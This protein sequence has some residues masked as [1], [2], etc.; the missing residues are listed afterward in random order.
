[1][2]NY[3][4]YSD[5]LV[6]KAS[7]KPVMTREIIDEAPDNWLSFYP[8][9]SFVAILRGL[10]EKFT[11]GDRSIWITGTYGS[12][13]SYAALVL[14]KL[15]N[16]DEER[17]KRFFTENADL[18]APEQAKAYKLDPIVLDSWDP[19]SCLSEN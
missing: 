17:V 1:M 14:Q 13:K 2:S 5:Y 6:P 4:H 19:F 9:P 16:D 7:Y 15:F 3:R 10:I 12:G 8:H 18:I 11:K